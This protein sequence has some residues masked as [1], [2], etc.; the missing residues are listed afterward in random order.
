MKKEQNVQVCPMCGSQNFNV[1]KSNKY[2]E[3]IGSSTNYLCNNC[4]NVFSFPVELSK[5][6]SEKLSNE[7]ME[8]IVNATPVEKVAPIGFFHVRVMFKIIGIFIIIL[9]IS[10]MLAGEIA[11]S[12]IMVIFGIAIILYSFKRDSEIKKVK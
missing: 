11:R 10:Y 5:Q 6:D 3:S 4:G 7:K 2:L 8:K 1:D 9:G 12:L